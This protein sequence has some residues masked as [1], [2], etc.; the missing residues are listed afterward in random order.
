[1]TQDLP[2]VR[3]AV[4]TSISL[5]TAGAFESLVEL[6]YRAYIDA[7]YGGVTDLQ[8][9]KHSISAN[10]SSSTRVACLLRLQIEACSR[11]IR[12]PVLARFPPMLALFFAPI[13][14]G[15]DFPDGLPRFLAEPGVESLPRLGR[16]R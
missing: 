6:L 5:L 2:D 7:S 13:P 11:S 1:M 4:S 8:L 15:T 12:L 10:S 9:S 16:A 14:A 3:K